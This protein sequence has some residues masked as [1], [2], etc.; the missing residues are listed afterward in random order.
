MQFL[1]RQDRISLF[2]WLIFVFMKRGLHFATK[3]NSTDIQNV[4]VC[5]Y[6]P[7]ICSP[8]LAKRSFPRQRR[9]SFTDWETRGRL[10]E[11]LFATKKFNSTFWPKD[12]HPTP[13]FLAYNVKN[14]NWPEANQLAVTRVT[15]EL[16]SELLRTNPGSSQGGDWTRGLRITI[17]ALL[18]ADHFT[19]LWN[20]PPTPPLNQH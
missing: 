13:L 12:C 4:I 8:L 9:L 5:E 18:T 17:P 7:M 15:E 19:F 6:P 10:C 1:H 11:K 2:N 16:N 20:C 14:S 3:L